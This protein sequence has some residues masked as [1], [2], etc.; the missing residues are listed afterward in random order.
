MT[1]HFVTEKRALIVIIRVYGE[2][3][4]ERSSFMSSAVTKSWRAQIKIVARLKGLKKQ[5]RI[6]KD[7]DSINRKK[8]NSSHHVI[9]D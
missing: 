3:V 7:V 5:W 2:I 4:A 9:N 1:Y 6:T 8:R